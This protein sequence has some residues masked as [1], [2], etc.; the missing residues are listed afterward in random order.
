VPPLRDRLVKTSAKIVRYD[1][2]IAF[3]MAGVMMPR[4]PLQQILD[5]IAARRPE[6]PRRC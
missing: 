2:S 5:A 6:T 3:Q 4:A 1:R